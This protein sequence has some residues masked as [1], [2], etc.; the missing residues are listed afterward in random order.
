VEAVFFL[1][2]YRSATFAGLSFS[3]IF[4]VFGK[5]E[6]KGL[7]SFFFGRPELIH[8]RASQPREQNSFV[9]QIMLSSAKIQGDETRACPS[10]HFQTTCLY[11][12]SY[13]SGVN[14]PFAQFC[15]TI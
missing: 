3:C 1:V 12:F 8:G 2:P 11:L 14:I 7:V 6:K 9:F 10:V 15:R 13:F 4:G 5:D